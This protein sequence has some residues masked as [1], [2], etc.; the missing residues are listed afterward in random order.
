MAKLIEIEDYS[1]FKRDTL[2][3]SQAVFHS[4]IASNR[5]LVRSTGYIHEPGEVNDLVGYCEFLDRVW[6]LIQADQSN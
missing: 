2:R 5:V 4:T 1:F 3:E 6:K